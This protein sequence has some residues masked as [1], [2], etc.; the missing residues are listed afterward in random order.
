MV[1]ALSAA[2]GAGVQEH[3]H[4]EEAVGQR[5][6]SVH[7]P[8]SCS[9]LSQTHFERGVALLHSFGY[10]AAQKEFQA[11]EKQEPKC[12]MAYWG[13]AM[14][15]YPQLWDRPSAKDLARGKELV[16]RGQAAGPKTAREEGFRHAAVAFYGGGSEMPFEARADSY[17]AAL[18]RLHARFPADH[19]AAIFSALR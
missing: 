2:A 16:S 9:P 3:H 15:L 11:I 4:G 7:F 17:R 18:A 12:A 1:V 19:E 14:T 13:E 8:I 6:G 10:G 5:L